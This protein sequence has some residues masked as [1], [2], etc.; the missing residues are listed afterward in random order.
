[1]EQLDTEVILKIVFGMI[2]GLG[3]F[4]LGMKNM[5]DG[6]QAVAGDSLRKMISAVTTNRFMATGVGTAVTCVVQS[7]SI[8]TVLVIGSVN[9]GVMTLVQAIGIILGAN[10][11]TTITG[12]ILVLKIG[13]YGLPLLGSM[14]LA[15]LFIKGDRW[16]FWALTLMGVGMVF[17][18]LELMK[19]ACAGIKDMPAFEAWFHQFQANNFWGVWKCVLAGCVLTMM[20]QSSSATLG[21]T[22]SLAFQGV[23][24]YETAAALVLGENIGTTV[25]AMLASLG[26]TVNARRAA[27]FHMIFNV[28]GVIW[29]TLIFQWYVGFVPTVIEATASTLHA[30]GLDPA[31]MAGDVGEMVLQKG[32]DGKMEEVYP[33]TTAAIAATHSIFNVVNTLLFLPLLGLFV[34]LLERLVPSK[35][36]K[37]KPH[38]SDLD[39][40]MLDTPPL[41]IEQSRAELLKMGD[42]CDKMLEWLRTLLGQ[43]TLDDALMDRISRREA[44]LDNIQD[45]VAVFITKLLSGN[46]THAVA[47]EARLQVRIADEYESVSDYITNIMKFQRRLHKD[48][49]RFTANQIEQLKNLH[50]MVTDY[51]DVVNDAFQQRNPDVPARL[52]TKGKHIRTE[53]KNMRGKHLEE[54]SADQ[55]DPSVGVAFMAALNSYVRVRDHS[56]NIAEA[57]AGEK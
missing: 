17:F 43:E 54:L 56:R 23:I 29:I 2:G 21:I 47:E 41:A 10:I 35:D 6:M 5:S 37:E 31:F 12:W 49:L 38:L 19:D 8:T 40:R 11:G 57:V 46:V 16:R 45:E 26:A 7:S 22:I 25:T 48:G 9:S 24:S 34:P 13:K 32:D 30:V 53:I 52:D 15:Y 4:L 55:M 39:I 14:A 28:T 3:I 33:Y 18:G 44:V 50:D 51:V 27:Y 42:G 1:M 20:V 36:F